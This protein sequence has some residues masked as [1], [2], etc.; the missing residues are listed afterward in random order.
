M[1]MQKNKV[2]FCRNFNIKNME[3]IIKIQGMEFY[4]FHGCFK[5]EQI[6]GGRFLVDIDI[7]TDCLKA[8]E[9]DS[10]KDAL[11]YQAIYEII[12][13]E[14]KIK[15][16][17]LEHVAGR[18]LDRIYDKFDSIKHV[19]LTISKVNPPL[20]GQVDKVSVCFKK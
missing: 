13:N 18:I 5:E 9:S 6:V 15:S 2:Y 17:L 3:S 14:M 20:G 8:A 4:A 7:T 16:H 11:N 19:S 1:K 10:I 12:R